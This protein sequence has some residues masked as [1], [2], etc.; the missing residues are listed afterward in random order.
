MNAFLSVRGNLLLINLVV[1]GLILWLTIS[2]LYL[3]ASQRGEALLLQSS[4]RI[5]RSISL[6]SNA[7]AS[8]RS[9]IESNLNANSLVSADQSERM[10]FLAKKTDL[11]FNEMTRL[12]NKLMSN[13][14][15]VAII[16]VT[17]NTLREQLA[18]VNE[19]HAR[20]TAQ[21][22]V[23]RI[24]QASEVLYE[25]QTEVQVA[26]AELAVSV[27]FLPDFN[28]SEIA[29]YHALLNNILMINIDLARK[30]THAAG[31][32]N[33][34]G[35]AR[36][37]TGFITA[38]LNEKIEER[39]ANLV[40]L[41]Q[42]NESTDQLHLLATRVQDYYLET[43]RQFEKTVDINAAVSPKLA[44]TQADWL[45]MNTK[46]TELI[47]ELTDKTHESIDVLATSLA[48][49]ATKNFYIDVFLVF[50]CFIITLATILINRRIKRYA[51]YDS[52][53]QLANRLNF[54]STLKDTTSSGLHSHAVIF[55]DL[56]RF[57][58]INDNYGHSTGDAVLIEVASRLKSA[59]KSSDLAARLGGDEFA[60]LITDVESEAAVEALAAH[61]VKSIEQ[62]IHVQDLNLKVGA[63]AGICMTPQDCAGGV[64]LLRNADIAMYHTKSAKLG[65]VFRFNPSI[66]ETYQQRLVLEQELKKGLEGGQFHVVYQ[67]KVSTKNGQVKSVEALLRWTHPTRGPISPGEFIPVAEDIGLMGSIGYWVLREACREIAL[68]QKAGLPDLQV[69]VNISP[70]QFGDE[71]FVE[72]LCSEIEARGLTYSSLTLEVTESIVMHDVDRVI[73]MLRKLQKLGIDIA[74]DDFGTGYSS[75]QYLQE[76]PLNTLKIDRAFILAL[77]KTDDAQRSV[78]NSIVQLASLFNLETVAEGIETIEQELQIRSLGVHYIQGY[79]YSKPVDAAELPATIAAI[80]LKHA[81]TDWDQHEQAA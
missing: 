74:V 10:I 28:A 42:A 31:V 53:T 23:A 66:A 55:F 40:K 56:D 18:A 71:H 48:K 22:L 63:S 36:P 3:A 30:N 19:L 45:L 17:N 33:S 1:V 12:M 49:R 59:C 14:Q 2:F 9:Y 73:S 6:A 61:M 8:E 13:Q 11:M 29:N 62:V 15:F 39:F 5:E 72:R 46:L 35:N 58:A 41:S 27:K 32:L 20:L 21:R 75:L 69:A 70:Q 52:L 60:V 38:V 47:N 77:E 50:L 26:L 78:A 34:E 64:E 4:M 43:Y 80:A 51:Y 67:P 81:A 57:K 7:I 25:L 68:L 79:R 16:P 37:M 54:E 24:S 44:M 76:L 65:S